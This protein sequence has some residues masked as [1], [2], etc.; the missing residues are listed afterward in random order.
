ME[1]SLSKKLF[2]FFP[3]LFCFCLPFGSLF[4]S[5]VIVLWTISS[6]FNIDP[7]QLKKG[8]R[9]PTL[10]VCI[11]FFLLTVVSAFF[12]SDREDALFSIE[13]KMTLVLFPYLMF[14]FYWPLE[15]LKRC[16]IS[17]VSG[18][19]FACL[20]LIVRASLYAMN[21]DT[22]YFYYTLFSDFIHTSSFAMYLVLAI[23]F[24]T[25]LYHK[26]FY[27]QKSII[28]SSW[29]FV[30]IFIASIFLCSSKLGLI[31]FFICFTIV[32]FYRFRLYLK[33][34]SMVAAL[35]VV[36]A[37]AVLLSKLFPGPVDRMSSLS[38]VS[39]ENLDKTSSEST[40][41][42]IL[43][44]REAAD[45]IRNNFVFGTGVGDA[46]ASLYAA[47]E[48]NG[49][50]G[51]LEHKLNAHN[52]FLQTFIGMGVIGFLSLCILTFGMIVKG[53]KQRKFFLFIFSLLI[54][55]NFLVE[56]ML[57]RSDG[58][59]FFTFFLCFFNLVEEKQLLEADPG[60][61]PGKANSDLG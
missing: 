31:S 32:C 18:C 40:T 23:T 9:N 3:V 56:S 49:L 16:V 14:C 33:P 48:K 61:A 46:N 11:L 58:T 8:F 44:W 51:A 28:Y 1:L 27:T 25:L 57:Q 13:I 42:R 17:F 19:F 37:T 60:K 43:I 29:F 59:L 20:Y 35:L 36:F 6:L 10:W 47:Y 52:Q 26:W 24:V 12:S 22:G 15:I 38:A 30:F 41:V 4:I 53:V 2:Y 50:T 45:L 34:V 5:G 21:G 55:L 54:I 39:L 7:V